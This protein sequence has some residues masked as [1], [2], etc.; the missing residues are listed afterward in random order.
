MSYRILL[1]LLFVF[2]ELLLPFAA[3]IYL[4]AAPIYLAA[5][6]FGSS[7]L[8]LSVLLELLYRIDAF[9]MQLFPQFCSFI[10]LFQ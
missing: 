3:S 4:V 6:G 9:L 10:P 7:S 1:P 8:L 2:A 5:V